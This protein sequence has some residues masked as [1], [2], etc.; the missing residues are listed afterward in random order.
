[1]EILFFYEEAYPLEQRIAEKKSKARSWLQKSMEN[2][3]KS[4]PVPWGPT[5][6]W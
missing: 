6:W 4:N 2:Y 1:M 3:Q 5:M